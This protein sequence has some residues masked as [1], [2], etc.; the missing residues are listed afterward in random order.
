VY[1]IGDL[2]KMAASHS[3]LGDRYQKI[4]ISTSTNASIMG[5]VETQHSSHLFFLDE[6]KWREYGRLFLTR[7]TLPSSLCSEH[8]VQNEA[9][10]VIKH[11][12]AYFLSLLMIMKAAVNLAGAISLCR[13]RQKSRNIWTKGSIANGAFPIACSGGLRPAREQRKQKEI[14]PSNQGFFQGIVYVSNM[15]WRQSYHLSG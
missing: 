13:S 7:L 4:I 1:Y 10:Y 3:N 8:L 2:E 6:L 14:P 12:V 11:Y 5:W 15:V 9:P